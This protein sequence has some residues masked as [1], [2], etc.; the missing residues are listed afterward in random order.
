MTIQEAIRKAYNEGKQDG[1]L[2]LELRTLIM[3]NEG[4][5]SQIDVFSHQNDSLK[6]ENLFWEQVTRLKKGEPLEYIIN[7]ASFLHHRLFVDSRVL[8]PR[9]ESEELIA[10]L[11]EIISDY[12]EPRNYLVCADVGTG[13]GALAIALKELFPNWL[14]T[15]SDLSRE[16]LEVARINFTKEKMGIS[17]LE[18]DALTP[19][20]EKNMALD[21]IVSNPPYIRDL[22]DAQ[23]SVYNYEPKTALL[24]SEENN[25]YHKIFSNLQRVKKG[26]IFLAFEISPDL[27][28]M[29]KEEIKI[30]APHAEYRFVKDLNGLLRFLFVYVA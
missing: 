18:G 17:T 2:P 1:I 4:F 12:Y 22:N 13:S 5:S 26:S 28:E 24:L 9:G 11:S 8:I 16:A 10:N 3:K 7:E 14:I 19:F 20:I 29:L 27:E 6:N 15:A 21:I 23:A 30:Y 25:V